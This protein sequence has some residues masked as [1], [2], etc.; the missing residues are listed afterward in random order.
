MT[1]AE[2]ILS[3]SD[4]L[5]EVR[6]KRTISYRGGKRH[7]RLSCPSGFRLVRSRGSAI[8][9]CIRQGAI[10]RRRRSV[11]AKRRARRLKGKQA[12]IKRRRAR[13]VRRRRAAGL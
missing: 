8:G 3:F 4:T 10:E 5:L 12:V 7:R 6:A 9:K 11:S 13:T 1:R 2:Q